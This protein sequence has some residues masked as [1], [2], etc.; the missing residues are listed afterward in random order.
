[1]RVNCKEI[2]DALNIN[3]TTVC[4]HL[5]R[6]DYKKKLDVKVA[7][8]LT[9]RNLIDWISISEMWLKPNEIKS[10][11]KRI[12]ACDEKLAKYGN[13][14]CQRSWSN[15]ATLHKWFQSVNC[16]QTGLCRMFGRKTG[17][18]LSMMSCCNLT[19]PS[20]LPYTVHN[21]TL[22]RNPKRATKIG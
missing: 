2:A 16:R 5:K 10:F 17:R 9:E 8:E 15:L 13:I 12:I 3:H 20:I 19:K 14:K 4:N 7:H 21:S 18:E 1:M 6:T 11:L 22:W